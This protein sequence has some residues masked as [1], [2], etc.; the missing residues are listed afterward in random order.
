MLIDATHIRINLISI[1]LNS[2]S[3]YVII[4]VMNVDVTILVCL[5]NEIT[6]NFNSFNQATSQEDGP[7]MTGRKRELTQNMGY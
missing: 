3:L 5:G 2:L 6:R 4:Y 1:V 7:T